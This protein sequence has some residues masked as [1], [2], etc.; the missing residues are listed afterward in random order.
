LS[1]TKWPLLVEADLTEEGGISGVVPR[2]PLEEIKEEAH[3]VL[4]TLAEVSSG[5]HDEDGEIGTKFVSCYLLLIFVL[6]LPYRA[7]FRTIGLVSLP[8]PSRLSGQCWRKLNSTA[9]PN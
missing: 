3:G 7:A 6:I 8:W 4:S 9:L 1:T 5:A 2:S